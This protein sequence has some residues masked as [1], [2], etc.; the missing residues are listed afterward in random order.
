MR[1]PQA[2]LEQIPDGNFSDWV[3]KA[4]K[5]QLE[6]EKGLTPNY[7]KR[8]SLLLQE[9]TAVGRNL[10]QIARAANSGKPVSVDSKMMRDLS[11][12]IVMLKQEILEVKQKL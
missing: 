3:L 6:A 1:V 4:I 9:L 5:S 10:N 7:E 8:L 11:N 12:Q 2:V